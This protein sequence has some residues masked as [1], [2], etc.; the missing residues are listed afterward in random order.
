[1]AASTMGSLIGRLQAETE[2]LA[3]R[4]RDAHQKTARTAVAQRCIVE[5]RMIAGLER[6]LGPAGAGQDAGARDF[7]HQCLRR[8]AVF[9]VSLDD[10]SDVRIGPVHRL[11][12]AFDVARML[13]VVGSTGMVRKRDA[14]ENQKQACRNECDLWR[15]HRVISSSYGRVY[16]VVL[17][18]PSGRCGCETKMSLSYASLPGTRSSCSHSPSMS[19]YLRSG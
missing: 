14:A 9:G 15:H 18:E 6:T 11:H 10:K 17:T 13:H 8:L 16:L 19:S 12:G 1:M 4:Q 3:A 5:N 7:E 2:L